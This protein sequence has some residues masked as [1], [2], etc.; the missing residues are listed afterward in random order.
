LLAAV[1]PPRSEGV[2]RKALG[3]HPN[4]RDMAVPAV[5][6]QVSQDER[7]VFPARFYGVPVELEGP[8]CRRQHG[9]HD[10]PHSFWFAHPNTFP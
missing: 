5:A 9:R 7:H 3:V 8:V 4:Q 6:V 2:A 10:F 1:A